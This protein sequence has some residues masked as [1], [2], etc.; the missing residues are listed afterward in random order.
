[1]KFTPEKLSI[2]DERMKPFI[3][4]DEI[5]DLINKSIS[6]PERVREIIAKSLSKQRLTMEETA[7]L[8]N[9]S[10][11][12]LVS[13]IKK[14]A[15][16]LKEKVYG[17]RIVLFAPLYI[18]NFCSNN[19]KYCGFRSSNCDAERK[20]L[21]H[22][23]IIHEVEALEDNGQKRLILVFGEHKTYTPEFIADS[24]RLVYSVK[25]GNGEIRR[26]NINAAPL[27]IEG[28]RTVAE[29]GIGTYQVFQ[30]TYHPEAYKWYHLAGKK[31]DYN[32][33]ITSLDRAQEAGLDDV[34][35]GALFGLYDWRFE[36]LG[37]VRH[38]N[39]LEACYN[40]GPHTI[41]FPRIKDAA[42]LNLDDKYIVSDDDFKKLV[43]IIR[44]AV[45]Y[46]GLILTAREDHEVR[47][48]VLQYGVSQIDGGTKIEL[49]SYS[50]ISNEDQNLNKEQFK[51][52][53]ERSLSEVID[54][55]LDDNYLPSFCTACYRLGRTGEHFMEFS[56][57]GFIKKCCTPNAILTLAE[58]L[59]DYADNKLADKGWKAIEKGI[60]DLDENV[61]SKVRERLDRIKNG[62]RDLYF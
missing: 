29:A 5:W 26:V 25:K 38:T 20:T 59:V 31:A 51:I 54:E 28:F 61:A 46:T 16:K 3:D 30:E 37:L 35:I 23:E 18:G 24:A 50:D 7:V 32:W 27:D 4:P 34:G 60:Q 11:P 6:T 45:P 14:G 47:R 1:M 41:S 12:V 52:A 44:L 13:E 19:C 10:D 15:R 53:D 42:S 17:N 58:Y 9:T 57:P 62:E 56:V 40:I 8:I 49:G 36:V 55:L 43:A 2:R 22:D 33:R 39:H 21:N 48:E